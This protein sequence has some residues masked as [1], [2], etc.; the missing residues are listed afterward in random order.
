[1]KL[2]ATSEVRISRSPGE[3]FEAIVDPAQMSHYFIS[4]ASA[5]PEPGKTVTWKWA[6]VGAEAAVQIDEVESP[7]R[8][9]FTWGA[10]DA[11]THVEIVLEPEGAGATAVRVSDGPYEA[12]GEGDR[13]FSRPGAGL[14][15]L[16]PLPEGVDR[17]RHRPARG[18]RDREPQGNDLGR[19]G[20]AGLSYSRVALEQLAQLFDADWPLHEPGEALLRHRDDRPFLRLI[21]RPLPRTAERDAHEDDVVRLV[22]VV[23]HSVFEHPGLA[24]PEDL[25]GLEGVILDALHQFELDRL[26]LRVPGDVDQFAHQGRPE[27]T[28]AILRIDHDAHFGVVAAGIAAVPDEHAVGA[29][30][31]AIEGEEWERTVV[32]QVLGP[33]VDDA[34]GDNVVF[35]EIAFVIR[36]ALKE[37]EQGGRVIADHWPHA[38]RRSS[39]NPELLWVG[40]QFVDGHATFLRCRLAPAILR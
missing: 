5:R 26:D 31:V 18:E 2:T 9:S 14:D 10:P 15:A 30:A 28:I 34:F 17:A 23:A 35:E 33:A 22:V 11:A 3:V 32:V 7:R 4:S 40:R 27:P 38:D 20:A 12:D 8:F 37:C 1:M 29:D 21:P 39:G 6:D 19:T 24:A 13:T 16:P 36:D 25:R